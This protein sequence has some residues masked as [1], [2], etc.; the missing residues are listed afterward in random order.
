MRRLLTRRV[1][2]VREPK[3]EDLAAVQVEQASK[4][5][6]YVAVVEKGQLL[7]VHAHE[8]ITN[9]EGEPNTAVRG[10]HRVSGVY[11]YIFFFFFFGARFC[12]FSS[13]RGNPGLVKRRFI[14]CTVALLVGFRIIVQRCDGVAHCLKDQCASCMLRYN[15]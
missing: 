14:D 13:V 2:G 11:I 5:G 6:D 1:F 7:V 12:G 4:D 15:R 9:L 10:A 8:S 3:E